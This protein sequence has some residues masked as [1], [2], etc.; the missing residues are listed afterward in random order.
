MTVTY[1]IYLKFYLGPC[2]RVS[3]LRLGFA[4]DHSSWRWLASG[5]CTL[6]SGTCPQT[7]LLAASVHCKYEMTVKIVS[8]ILSY[9]RFKI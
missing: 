6:A 8:K 2:Y 3:E 7:Y 9:R 5:C 4:V 1:L